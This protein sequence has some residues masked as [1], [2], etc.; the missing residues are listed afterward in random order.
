MRLVQVQEPIKVVHTARTF[1]PQ[2]FTWRSR[3]H[4]VWKIDGVKAERIGHAQGAAHR[5]VFSIQ[6]HRGMRCSISYNEMKKRWR[7]ETMN[8]KGAST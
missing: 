3:Q 7:L 1:V 8:T 4:H 5:R 2:T 6:T